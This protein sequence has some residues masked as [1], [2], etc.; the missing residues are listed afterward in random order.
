MYSINANDICHEWFA[1]F[2]TELHA[3]TNNSLKFI[4]CHWF[5][6]FAII[7]YFIWETLKFGRLMT[8]KN[9]TVYHVVQIQSIRVD[10]QL[11][12]NSLFRR[13]SAKCKLNH[14]WSLY[15]EYPYNNAKWPKNASFGILQVAVLFSSFSCFLWLL[16]SSSRSV[17]ISFLFR[18]SLRCG[19][20]SLA[21]IIGSKHIH[22]IYRTKTHIQQT[23]MV[24]KLKVAN[25]RQNCAKY[26]E[27]TKNGESEN[28][29]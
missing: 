13:C 17:C 10:F 18:N 12:W 2:S 4:T 7:Q 28:K 3:H 19:L 27:L 11:V 22:T 25:K 8:E 5:N 15:N 9:E 6:F 14:E 1:F 24:P 21:H 26:S 23:Y 16:D 29:K 20:Y